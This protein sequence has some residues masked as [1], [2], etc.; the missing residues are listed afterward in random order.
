M[1]GGREPSCYND[2]AAASRRGTFGLPGGDDRG[3][4]RGSV[5]RLPGGRAS[6]EV[7]RNF[8]WNFFWGV[9]DGAFFGVYLVL[10]DV[11]LV[12]PWMLNQLTD[13]RTMIGLA[14]TIV[15]VGSSLPQ[16]FAA[17][18]VQSDPYRKHWVVRFA[19]LR[20]LVYSPMLPFLL[21]EISGPSVVLGAFLLSYTLSS[22]M[23]AFSALSWQDMYA[24][25]LPSR[26]L[27]SFFGLRSF[28]GGILGLG[29][30]AFV[31]SY[32]GAVQT[33]P[34]HKFGVLFA[35]GAVCLLG[36]TFSNGMVREPPG[37]VSLEQPPFRVQIRQAA[38]LAWDDRS[39]R[40]F[41][42]LRALL[43]VSSLAAPLYIVEGRTRYGILADSLG[44]FTMASLVAGIAAS[45]GWSF[46]GDRLRIGGLL[47]IVGL[48]AI[49]PPVIA[50]MMPV[51]VATPLGPVGGWL[52]VFVVLGAA[53]TGQQNATFRGAL[54]LPSPEHRSLMIGLGNT[55]SGL[56]S[57]VGPLVG[58]LADVAGP[59]AAFML[60]A[61]AVGAVVVLSGRLH[62]ADRRTGSR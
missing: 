42:I 29:V 16:L 40:Y 58:L 32:L 27:S 13:S 41:L 31:R 56:V 17:R 23:I 15:L 34:L 19:L 55:F 57:L 52:I 25:V 22:C 37:P 60:A 54:E 18:L 44:T 21:W 35:I 14:P 24:K 43:I 38:R 59:S 36:G 2:T 49:L 46:L 45:L 1:G 30:A 7:A 61:L 20:V 10:V 12:I 5:D 51:I 62:P 3:V 9:M 26:R 48:L 28:I 50:L 33:V 39:Y 6:G 4:S 8:S 11:N 47:R 53:N